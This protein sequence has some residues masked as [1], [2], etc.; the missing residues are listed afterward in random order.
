MNRETRPLLV[1]VRR[2]V[3]AR[4]RADDA[5]T[6]ATA[7]TGASS[8]TASH[9]H[10]YRRRDCVAHDDF[11][12]D[13]WR[14]YRCSP[15]GI[16]RA[17]VAVHTRD[18]SGHPAGRQIPLSRSKLRQLLQ[19]A[20]EHRKR[21]H[22]NTLIVARGLA[23][24]T[25]AGVF[26]MNIVRTAVSIA[27][28]VVVASAFAKDA[29][30]RSAAELTPQMREVKDMASI[31]I[32]AEF[33]VD[34][35]KSVDSWAVIAKRIVFKSGATLV[36]SQQAL[37]RRNEL[38]IA[39]D[40]IVN[41]DQGHPGTVT[42]AQPSAA[43]QAPPMS[44]QAPAGA[45]GAGDGQSGSPGTPGASG[46]SGYPGRNSP[47]LTV[48]VQRAVGGGQQIGFNGQAG[49]QG[50]KGQTGGAGGLGH[51]GSPASASLFDCHSGAGYGGNGGNGGPGGTG[52]TGGAGGA[53]GSVTLVS[54]P[55]NLG[56]LTHLYRVDVTGGAG[57]SG[58]AGG[59]GGSP[60]A[61]GS[62]G[63]KALPYCKDEPSR[64]GHG[65]AAG[66]SGNAGSPGN[67]GLAGDFSVAGVT[68][69]QFQRMLEGGGG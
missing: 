23:R 27:S 25:P 6:P 11:A 58:G 29:T 37:A 50:G 49:G 22:N 1:L 24:A 35:Q 46:N 32:P 20:P 48:F 53:G 68:A 21:V 10:Q 13:R 36:F 51:K 38:L 34:G 5:C 52:G 9:Q 17:A 65:G 54:L 67:E 28:L 43:T 69:E 62:Q 3:R 15:S 42:W 55:E 30:V 66:A 26:D 41:E 40:T 47:I 18:Q 63:E 8:A 57:G 45:H 16:E 2:D 31:G 64:A 60:G 39:A 4:Q 7:A 61:G 33:V 44:G 14:R 12:A 59:D 19:H 56:P